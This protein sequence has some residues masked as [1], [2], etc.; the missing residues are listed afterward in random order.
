MDSN[1][2]FLALVISKSSHFTVLIEAHDKLGHQGVNR[3]YHLVKHQYYRKGMN[4]D[5]CK[6]ISNCALCERK[7]TRTQVYL[8]QMTHCPCLHQ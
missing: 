3:A 4:K 5:I 1:Q 7:K 6:Y 8:L 2:R